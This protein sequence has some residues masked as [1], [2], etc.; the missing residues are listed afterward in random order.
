M[1]AERARATGRVAVAVA[2]ASAT[3]ATTVLP[4]HLPRSRAN[5]ERG[6]ASLRACTKSDQIIRALGKKL[7][8]ARNLHEVTFHDNEDQ[9]FTF[10]MFGAPHSPWAP[11]HAATR[12]LPFSH[13]P[14]SPFSPFPYAVPACTAADAQA[15]LAR[16]VILGKIGG[17]PDAPAM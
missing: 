5:R 11:R 10:N 9:W 15:W 1:A 6:S 16:D 2:T 4:Q 12:S 8:F 7:H 17:F 13:F 14:P 3:E